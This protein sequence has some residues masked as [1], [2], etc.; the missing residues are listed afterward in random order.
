MICTVQIDANYRLK[1]VHRDQAEEEFF[2]WFCKFG[3]E[4]KQDE[5][6]ESSKEKNIA[7]VVY[8][9]VDVAVYG[10]PFIYTLSFK[11]ES[12]FLISSSAIYYPIYQFIVLFLFTMS[13]IVRKK[14]VCF[15]N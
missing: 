7:I 1:E 12:I 11:R 15:L 9:F 6:K 2:F 5:D 4:T 10:F 14:A 8:S 3:E 13:L